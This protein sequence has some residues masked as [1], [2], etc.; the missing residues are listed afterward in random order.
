MAAVKRKVQMPVGD[1]EDGDILE[2]MPIDIG[3]SS[4]TAVKG[5]QVMFDCGVHPAHTG[6][7]SLPFFEE[8]DPSTVDLA[9]IT[10]F[11]PVAAP[12]T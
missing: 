10:H 3:T 7:A 12:G 2:I 8:I 1:R 5:K 9:L 6:L 4:S 11:H